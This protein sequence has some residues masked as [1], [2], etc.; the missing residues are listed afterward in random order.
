MIITCEKCDTKF[1]FDESRLGH[2]GRKVRCANCKHIWHVN[3][4]GMEE[5]VKAP[6]PAP[7]PAPEP[8]SKVQPKIR[9]D[10]PEAVAAAKKSDVP[11]DVKGG[12]FV[13][14]SAL[15]VAASVLVILN[16]VSFIYFNKD[17]IGQTAFYDTVGNYETKAVEIVSP[18]IT[19]IPA[20]KGS[21]LQ[22]AWAVKNTSTKTLKMPIVRFR[23]Y[24]A[25][26][27]K[28]GEKR[29]ERENVKIPAGEELKFKD[30]LIHPTKVARYF[31]VEI[32]NTTELATR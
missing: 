12:R 1:S 30:T 23:L 29:N 11:D 28:I 13:S 22:I 6:T 16:F 19:S 9:S 17:I 3:P 4:P 2:A 20:E 18:Q 27:D 26:L 7:V 15:K 21:N 14:L 32:G 25:D 31:V 10:K 5:D 24:G 8:E